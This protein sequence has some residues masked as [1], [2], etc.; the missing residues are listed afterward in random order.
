LTP[1]NTKLLLQPGLRP[2]PRWE[3]TA[4]PDSLAGFKGA[5]L[6]QGREE[7]TGVKGKGERDGRRRNGG[8]GRQGLKIPVV[9]FGNIKCVVVVC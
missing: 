6:Q 4:L 9:C 2:R 5:A 1:N 3:L 7:D 8:R